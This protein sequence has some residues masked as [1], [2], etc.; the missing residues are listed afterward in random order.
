MAATTKSDFFFVWIVSVYNKPTKHQFTM[1]TK[2]ILAKE[3]KD[4]LMLINEEYLEQ[5]TRANRLE[6]AMEE[7]DQE[8]VRLGQVIVDYQIAEREMSETI[9]LLRAELNKRDQA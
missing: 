5:R 3:L 1:S 7:Q 6:E 9:D 8:I 2:I 4:A